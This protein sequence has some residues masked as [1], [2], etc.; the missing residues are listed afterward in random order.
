[1]CAVDVPFAETIIVDRTGNNGVAISVPV[2]LR[3][4][5]VEIADFA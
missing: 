1:L 3:G 4:H 5:V 2:T